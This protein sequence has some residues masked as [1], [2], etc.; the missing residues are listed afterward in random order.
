[1]SAPLGDTS[2]MDGMTL[3]LCPKC[4]EAM[5]P[6]V[7]MGYVYRWKCYR[8]HPVEPIIL[9]GGERKGEGWLGSAD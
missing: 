5:Q 6:M 9:R 4:G 8:C 3:P 2:L 1:M 7:F